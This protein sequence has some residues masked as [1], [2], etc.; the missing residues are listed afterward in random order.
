MAKAAEEIQRQFQKEMDAFKANQVDSRKCLTA[1]QQLEAQ[2]TENKMVM[3]E[4]K[5]LDEDA[6]LFK[7]IGPILVKQDFIEAKQNVDKRIEYITREISRQETSMKDL[8]EKQ[9]KMKETLTKL[10]SQM[11]QFAAAR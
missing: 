1:R 9:D 6:S 10:Q 8:Q 7:M 4:M 11:Q 2:L 3:E 5:L